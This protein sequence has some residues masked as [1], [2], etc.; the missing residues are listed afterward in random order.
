MGDYR[1]L[2]MPLIFDLLLHHNLMISSV[3]R[4]I[5][6]VLL[7]SSN[8]VVSGYAEYPLPDYSSATIHTFKMLYSINC[9]MFDHLQDV[10][11]NKK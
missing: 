2:Y 4:N 7:F 9:V 5:L 8:A 11:K 1:E 10:S 3:L 6:Y